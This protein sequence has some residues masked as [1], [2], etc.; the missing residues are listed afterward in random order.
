MIG[1]ILPMVIAIALQQGGAPANLEKPAPGP[2]DLTLRVDPAVSM[3]PGTFRASA[4]IDPDPTNRRLVL[5]V[6]S[7]EYY[8]S[9]TTFLEGSAAT[10]AHHMVFRQLPEGTY[11][12][13]AR[14]ERNDGTTVVDD[15][16]V[17]VVR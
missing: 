15:A 8:R 12:V 9:S 1:W 7:A 11:R 17:R 5:L 6:D 13:E 2:P 4:Y 16:V 14:L 10:R 3:S